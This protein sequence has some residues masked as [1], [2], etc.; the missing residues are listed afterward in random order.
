MSTA[1]VPI[2]VSVAR[3]PS[4]RESLHGGTECLNVCDED[5]D[6]CRAPFGYPCTGD[7][8]VCTDDVCSGFGGCLHIAN[9]AQCD[10]GVF[11]DGVDFCVNGSCSFSA[12]IPVTPARTARTPATSLPTDARPTS[13]SMHG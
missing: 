6:T 9:A 11:C 1:T 7:G 5:L 2:S 4:T 12:G 13:G 10:D 3:V 8:N